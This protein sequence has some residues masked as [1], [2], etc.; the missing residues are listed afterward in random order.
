[1]L[2]TKVRRVYRRA[3]CVAARTT[4]GLLMRAPSPAECIKPSRG[5]ARLGTAN[6]KEQRL[7][8]RLADLPVVFVGLVR[9]DGTFRKHSEH[10]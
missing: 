9:P 3:A 10:R 8:R 6:D 7:Q 5:G 1:M 2:H 4:I